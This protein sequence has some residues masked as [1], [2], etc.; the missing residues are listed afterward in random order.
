[1]TATCV[2]RRET[3]TGKYYKIFAFT[4]DTI[5]ANGGG[6]E[7]HPSMFKK[8]FSSTK[9]KGVEESEKEPSALTSD[10]F[11]VIEEVATLSVKEAATGEYMVCL[12]LLL[13]NGE[14]YGPLKMQLDDNGLMGEPSW[15]QRD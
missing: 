15:K 4:V 1:M 10:E 14:R 13:V 2:H 3:I 5:N 7:L 6:A 12:F 11:K 8:S 9:D